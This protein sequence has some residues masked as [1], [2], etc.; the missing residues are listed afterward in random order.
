MKIIGVSCSPRASGNTVAM[1]TEVLNAAKAE[2]AEVELFSIA[3]KNIQPCDGC[4]GCTKTGKC[5]IKDDVAVLQDKMIA[6]DG[7]IFGTPVYFWG[8]TAQA[9][10]IMDRTIALNKPERSLANKVCGVVASCGSLGMV[11]VLKDY[12]YYI[13]QRR[14]LPANQVSAYL[15][16]PA[17]LKT[18]PKC[19]E[20]L[21]KLGRQMVALIKMNF[22][23]PDEFAR[24]PG[25]FGTHT[26]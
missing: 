19:L 18:M 13:V 3:G 4:W 20:E 24:G 22:K 26:R 14:M 23:Y 7:I 11:D 17:D 1:L 9:K 16:E 21:N 8:M 2:G 10:A 5:H 15:H 6:A 25:A 12:S